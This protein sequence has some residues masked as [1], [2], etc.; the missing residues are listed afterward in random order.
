MNGPKWWWQE[1]RYDDGGRYWFL[2]VKTGKPDWCYDIDDKGAAFLASFYWGADTL[3]LGE[4]KTLRGAK[5]CCSRHARKMAA[6]F[7]KVAEA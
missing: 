4:F 3:T 6:L 1:G 5:S 2:P 7:A